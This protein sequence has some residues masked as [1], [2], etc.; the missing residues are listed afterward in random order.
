MLEMFE[1][2]LSMGVDEAHIWPLQHRTGNAIAGNRNADD[3]YLTMGGAIFDMMSESLGP[4]ESSIGKD[5]V[6]YLQDSVWANAKD[7]IEIN[8]FASDYEDVLYVSLRDLTA[9]DVTLS[10]NGLMGGVTDVSVRQLS[11]DDSSSDGL[12]DFSGNGDGRIGK[13]EIT[14]D[15]LAQLKTLAFFDASDK[16]H[17]T[18]SGSEIK[19]Y[20]PPFETIIPLV[21]NPKSIDDY[22]FATEMDVAPEITDVSNNLLSSGKINLDFMPYDVVEIT[23]T[24]SCSNVGSNINETL[25]GG[26]GQDKL[27][28]MAGAD[29]LIAGEGDDQLDGG[30]GDDTL[31]AGHGD[32]TIFASEGKDVI[33]GGGGTDMV[34]FENVTGRV[35]ID[36][37]VS[38]KN[39][40]FA[41]FFD[42]GH[43][44]N[45]TYSNVEIYHGGGSADNLRG[46]ADGNVLYGGGSSDRLY[47]RSGNDTLF[48][49]DGRDA[50]YGN[51]GADRMTGGDQVGARDRYI[52]FSAD[53]S[54]AGW[55]NRDVIT[56][57]EAGV[58]RIEIS[59]LDADVTTVVKDAFI[60]IADDG[61]SGTA[62]ELGYVHS[63]SNTIVQADLDGDGNADFEIQL[64]GTLTL[65]EDDFLI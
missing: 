16:N 9:S 63:D 23:L 3:V 27:F 59:R 57:F 29:K 50:I 28:G 55:R 32:D 12:S 7:E 56:D 43:A 10:L 36:M 24:H 8:H 53:E 62:G 25:I 65:T 58:D 39:K 51:M 41:D 60:F 64:L 18:Y 35:L 42:N 52:Y 33:N 5:H 22:Y 31:A 49:N 38:V 37:Q 15:E 54:E 13:R 11:I 6:F 2:M 45:D 26:Y 1:Y 30:L 19:T 20:L 47:G 48:G 14:E 17:V 61:F 21:S 40:G 34:S 46:D 44:T 4:D